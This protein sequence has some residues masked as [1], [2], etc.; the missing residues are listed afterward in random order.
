MENFSARLSI[1]LM[2]FLL[3]ENDPYE[4]LDADI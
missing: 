1:Y 2:L 3:V 4:R